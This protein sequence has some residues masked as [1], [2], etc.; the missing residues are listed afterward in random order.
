MDENNELQDTE[1]MAVVEEAEAITMSD[2][3]AAPE[4]DSPVVTMSEV[5]TGAPPAPRIPA[6]DDEHHGRF[7]QDFGDAI[8]NEMLNSAIRLGGSTSGAIASSYNVI[9][10]ITGLNAFK[11]YKETFVAPGQ[12]VADVAREV[13]PGGNFFEQQYFG[14]IDAIGS[15]VPTIPFDVMTGGST[16]LALVGRVLPQMERALSRIPGFALGSGW[17]G[18][19]EGIQRAGSV[20]GGVVEGMVGAAENVAWGSL[21]AASGVGLKGIGKMASLGMA[22]SFYSAAKEGRTPTGQ[23]ITD[24]TT[25]AAM[26]GV[27]FTALPHLAKGSQ[28]EAEKRALKRYGKRAEAVKDPAE[29]T[30]IVEDLFSDTRIRPEIR[31]SLARPFLDMMD[32][33]GSIAPMEFRF[34]M[35]KDRSKLRMYRETMER[36]IENVA[37]PDAKAVQAE[38]TEKI[39]EN[40]TARARWQ[41]AIMR[42]VRGKEVV[43]KGIKPGSKESALMMRY[44]EGRMTKKELQAA[45][46]NKWGEIE[47]AAAYCR[48]VY[49]Q[50]L[51]AHNAVRAK[52]GYDPIQ[53]VPDY[54]RH[55]QELNLANEMFGI[56]LGGKKPPTEIAGVLDRA[57][58]GKPFS[59]VEYERVGG[60]FKEDGVYALQNYIKAAGQQIFHL[61]SVQRV[62]AL[63]NY[64]RQQALVN[65]IQIRDGIPVAK[66]DLSNFVENISQYADLLAGQPSALTK[67]VDKNVDRPLVACIRALQRN[68]VANMIGDNISASFMNVLPMA[69]GATMLITNPKALVKGMITSG[70][71]LHHE[72]PFEID[73]V[74]SELYDRRH[75]V[76]FLPENWIESVVEHSFILP[77]VFDRFV[78]QTLIA[79]KYYEGRGRGLNPK[80]AMKAA[81]NEVSRMVLD[82]STGQVP[83]LMAEPNLKIFTAFQS[84]I[85]NLWSWMV[86]DVAGNKQNLLRTKIGQMAV[87]AVACNVINNVYEKTMGRRPQL[88][89]LYILGTL[90]GVTESGRDRD[91]GARLAAAGK[92]FVGNVPFG[93][94]FV[95]G[96]RFPIASALPDITMKEVGDFVS[97]N[98]PEH[99][100]LGEMLRPTLYWHPFGG[101]GQVRK[102]WEGV[103]AWNQGYVTTPS[104]N[105]RYEVAKDFAN[106]VR[107]FLF[108]K[109]SFPEAVKYWAEP[110]E[111][112]D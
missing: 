99:R 111:E 90:F 31:E 8:Y 38:T 96:G 72:V 51:D 100:I 52:Y 37:G 88:D 49:D 4:G 7:L 107:G 13:A 29:I 105:V 73:G 106:F 69:Q 110:P 5:E 18:M 86:H 33:R 14:L 78:V 21:F 77:K 10:A 22:Q 82:R 2:A 101:G 45:S 26:L 43:G 74:R 92:D 50:S 40:E 93:N 39:K 84:E 104:G 80:D 62:R 102:T 46:P 56:M 112:R 91:F 20:P 53:K 36:N 34:G 6:I 3:L 58:Y 59:S 64:I 9:G 11:A 15:L 70:L 44:G 76:G 28:I 32:A 19:V 89:F 71:H 25:Q 95:E 27:V 103:T 47:Q 1:L 87:F 30:K 75:P 67:A 79:G 55:F 60:P 85:N 97:W 68:V 94:L 48:R 35:W 65:E 17:R 98:D 108:G 63:E 83:L 12:E 41:S 42:D 61:D 54:F 81:D 66:L 109:N 16:K 24:S 57:K 23:E